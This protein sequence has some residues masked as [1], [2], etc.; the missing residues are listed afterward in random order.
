MLATCVIQPID[1]IKVRIQLG[2]GSAAQVTT[3]MLKNEGV[4]AFYK[5]K[6]RV[7]ILSDSLCGAVAAEAKKVQSSWVILDKIWRLQAW[8]ARASAAVRAANGDINAGD[9]KISQLGYNGVPMPYNGD[10]KQLKSDMAK[11][12]LAVIS[13]LPSYNDTDTVVGDL[14]PRVAPQAVPHLWLPSHE[15]YSKG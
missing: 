6:I 12:S 5:I 1:M 14:V 9:S 15:K 2:Q 8:E 13:S 4:A 3:T 11:I 10:T 7:K